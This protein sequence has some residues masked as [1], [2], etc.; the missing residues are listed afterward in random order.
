MA[1]E[2]TY[3]LAQNL[4]DLDA[5]KDSQTMWSSL[6]SRILETPSECIPRSRRRQ[7]E[8]FSEET[9]EIIEK[10]RKA[11]LDG[12][13]GLRKQLRHKATRVMQADL[14]S[15]VQSLCEA[16]GGNLAY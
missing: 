7:Q 1:Q 16:V 4:E 11:R 15:L 14:E 2:Y 13:T 6:K 10:C 5:S 8:G 12:K 3:K 9:V